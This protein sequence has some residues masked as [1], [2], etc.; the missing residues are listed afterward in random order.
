MRSE[1]SPL[2]IELADRIAE[3]TENEFCQGW[4]KTDAVEYIRYFARDDISVE[5][6]RSV[7]HRG[8]DIRRINEDAARARPDLLGKVLKHHSK[9]CSCEVVEI[10]AKHAPLEDIEAT[11]AILSINDEACR[12]EG[13]RRRTDKIHS[14]KRILDKD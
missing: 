1:P 13:R 14:L 8:L 12:H 3:K 10:I 2:A 9:K 6:L 11:I 5:D 7:L 4:G